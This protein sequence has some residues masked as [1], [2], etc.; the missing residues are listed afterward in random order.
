MSQLKLKDRIALYEE[1]SDYKLL[2]RVPI[3]ICIN[4]RSFSK[5]TSLME[6]P[7]CEKF[8]ECMYATALRLAMEV[9]GAVFSYCFGDE[10]VVIARNDQSLETN[11]W[12][13][14]RV[15]KI[16]S[17]TASIATLHFNNCA[18]AL[19]LNIMGDAIFTANAFV[20][21][22][23]TEAINVIVSKQQLSFQKSLHFAC[24]YELLNKKYDKNDIKEMIQGTSS[25]D[26]INLLQQECGIDFNNYP[27]AFRRGVACY[28]Q[29]KLIDGNLKHKWAVNMEI[30]IFT[31]EQSFL[32][33]IFHG[34][35]DII[36]QDNL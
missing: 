10:I 11:F 17:V 29:P 30:P 13:D 25:D 16:A 6:K 28:R 21:P 36:R 12:Y 18:T 23:V 3:I 32:S 7:Y 14:N 8:S 34:G 26:K 5:I 31:K 35:T 4:G 9:E 19:N 15:Q 2:G 33:N 1:A 20:V 24:L 22:N 27:I